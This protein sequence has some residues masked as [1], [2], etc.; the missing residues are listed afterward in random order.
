MA[1]EYRRKN[2]KFD[3]GFFDEAQD[4]ANKNPIFPESGRSALPP[5]SPKAQQYLKDAGVE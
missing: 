5:L 2:G 4:F 3:E 1:R